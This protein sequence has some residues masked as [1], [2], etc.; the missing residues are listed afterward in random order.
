VWREGNE[1]P[2]VVQYMGS[3]ELICATLEEYLGRLL[4]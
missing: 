2:A 4:V 1:E 3:Q